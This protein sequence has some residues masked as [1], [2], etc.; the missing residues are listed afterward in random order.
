MEAE[1]TEHFVFFLCNYH[2]INQCDAINSLMN[3]FLAHLPAQRIVIIESRI[4]PSLE[5]AP[6]IIQRKIVSL[7]RNILRFTAQEIYDLAQIQGIIPFSVA[8][9]EQIVASFDGWIAG[10]PIGNAFGGYPVLR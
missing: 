10:N 6:L 8:E 2:A 7:G 1:I 9:T 3:R 4:I 5:F